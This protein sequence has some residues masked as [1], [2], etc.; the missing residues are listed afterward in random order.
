MSEEV[1]VEKIDLS[2]VDWQSS[3]EFFD[4]LKADLK[5]LDEA[6]DKEVY[7]LTWP[8][9]R[10]AI[11]EAGLPINKTLRPD[12]NASKDFDSTKN[13]LIVGDNLDALKLLQESYLNKVK[14][15]YI[16]PPYNTGHD[17]VY[18]DNFRQS[19]AD[20]DDGTIDESGNRLVDDDEFKVNSYSNGRFHSDWLSMMYPRLKLARNLLTDD[21]VIFISI[22]DNEL[23]NTCELCDT[24][25]GEENRGGVAPRKTRGSATTKGDS[26]MQKINDYL[27]IY[28]KD[29][30][31][32]T[33]NKKIVGQKTYP[34]SDSRG[35]YY[36]VPLQDNGPHGTREARPN[37]WYPIYVLSNGA[38]T[39]D[40]SADYKERILPALHQRKEGRWMWSKEK[41]DRDVDDL[42]AINGKVYIKHYY[43]ESDDQNKYQRDKL[44]IGD[45]QNSKGTSE[46]NNLFPELPGLFSNPKPLELLDFCMNR[47]ARS[48]SLI[49]DFFAGSG[50]TGHA[51]MDLNAQDGGS[52]RYILAQY[53]EETADGSEARKAG[54]RTIDQIT[55]ERL[56]RAGD[57][58]VAENPD[59]KVDT[60]FRVLRVDSSNENDNI[61]QTP[62]NTTLQSLFES[63]NN[64][65]GDR[66]P[67]D[68]LFGVISSQALPLDE[69]LDIVESDD[70]TIYRYGYD[71]EGTGL[72]ACFDDTVSDAAIQAIAKMQPNIAVFRDSSFASSATK[73]NLSEHFRMLSPG[74][75]VKVI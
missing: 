18:H 34:Y 68:L 74:T 69:R 22:D 73:V 48:D 16:D 17:F 3:R 70:N 32:G 26:E 35:Q 46:L 19:K 25:F 20:Y 1:N 52:R 7:D 30:S 71:F 58:I 31:T 67:L 72:V 55:A 62:N 44:W 43:V 21:G 54:Y 63:V 66:G 57:K 2:N 65:K 8:G 40:E 14:M 42:V 53:P 60:G 11:V 75:K 47:G 23:A 49:L 39:R 5:R 12:V 29:K 61:R 33:F 64:I 36:I 59:T 24:I 6:D 38:L 15:I 51:V 4:S 27:V 56:R 50:T 41:F 10:G 37:L 9:K 13:M 45:C 28:F